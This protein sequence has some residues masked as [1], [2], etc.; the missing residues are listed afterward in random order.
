M[1]LI[2]V[3]GLIASSIIALKYVRLYNELINNS[4]YTIYREY[5]DYDMADNAFNRL[6]A[7]FDQ[8]KQFKIISLNKEYRR[9][10]VE[11]KSFSNEY[12]G[13]NDDITK[14]DIINKTQKALNQ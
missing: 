6:M 12:I 9:F 2:L 5:N 4:T 8:N 13:L 14:Y 3:I 1:T 7:I 10:E 11:Y